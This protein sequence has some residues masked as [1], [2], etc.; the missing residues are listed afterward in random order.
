MT[1]KEVDDYINAQTEPTRTT[2][3][4]MRK[5]LLEIEPNLEQVIAWKSAMFKFNGKYAIGLCAHKKHISFS[6]QSANVM[7]DLAKD[8]EG[9]VTSANSFQ[10]AQDK[11]LPKALVSKLLKARLKELKN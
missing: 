8:L 3:Q 4:T 1:V 5:L 6:P 9:Y 7:T 11:P 2:L 10:F